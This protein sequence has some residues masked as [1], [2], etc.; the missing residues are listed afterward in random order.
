S[1]VVNFYSGDYPEAFIFFNC[2]SSHSLL[3]RK[4]LTEYLFPF[5]EAGFHDAWIGYVACN[6]GR[7]NFLQEVLVFYRQ[8]YDS[9]TDILKLKGRT[10][11]KS[12]TV[13]YQETLKFIKKCKELPINKNP[14]IVL[15]LYNL[16]KD[17]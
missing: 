17:R 10:Q 9:A 4:E 12:K 3:F 13:K 11:K 16:Y 14:D 6:L 8:H 5:P 7:I 15:S 1:D 2:I